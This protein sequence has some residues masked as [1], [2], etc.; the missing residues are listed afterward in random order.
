MNGQMLK[1]LIMSQCSS[2]PLSNCTKWGMWKILKR[3]IAQHPM[4]FRATNLWMCSFDNYHFLF[5]TLTLTAWQWFFN[6]IIWLW[7]ERVNCCKVTSHHPLTSTLLNKNSE[8][9]GIPGLVS[10]KQ[11]FCQFIFC[12]LWIWLPCRQV[13][14]DPNASFN[15]NW[16]RQNK[17]SRQS[18]RREQKWAREH[19]LSHW[20]FVCA[21]I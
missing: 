6:F 3:R 15:I 4:E 17:Q 16:E 19:A 12:P 13:H 8:A 7:A 9:E 18:T 11:C 10:Q 5:I 21:L 20:H 2:F 14:A 1:A